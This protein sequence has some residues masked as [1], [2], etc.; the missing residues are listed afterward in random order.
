MPASAQRALPWDGRLTTR[1]APGATGGAAPVVDIAGAV[2]SSLA[3]CDFDHPDLPAALAAHAAA[4]PRFRGVRGAVPTGGPSAA[5]LAG[6]AVLVAVVVQVILTPPCIT[7]PCIILY[8][9]VHK[10]YRAA[11]EWR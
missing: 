8:E 10:I 6:F 1:P 5:W 3:P 2:I 7:I 11:S 9:L 4:S